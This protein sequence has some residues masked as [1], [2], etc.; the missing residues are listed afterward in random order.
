MISHDKLSGLELIDD[1]V[2]SSTFFNHIF[3]KASILEKEAPKFALVP[4]WSSHYHVE[5]TQKEQEITSVKAASPH[6][7]SKYLA[8]GWD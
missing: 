3:C 8:N 1:D 2:Q 4:W 6:D 7:G 5:T